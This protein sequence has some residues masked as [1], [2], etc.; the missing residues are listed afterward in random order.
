MQSIVEEFR[1][2][3]KQ[4]QL[5]RAECH[6]RQMKQKLLEKEKKNKERSKCFTRIKKRVEFS[7]S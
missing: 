5:E 4:G 2:T 6:E 1:K 7:E 3:Q